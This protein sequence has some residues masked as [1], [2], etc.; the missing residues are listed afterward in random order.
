V[1]KKSGE[2][3]LL[4]VKKEIEEYRE[5]LKEEPISSIECLKNILNTITEVKDTTMIMEFRI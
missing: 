5:K 4:Q 1:L 3:E 2:A